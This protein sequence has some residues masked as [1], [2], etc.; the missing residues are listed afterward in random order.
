MER[1]GGREEGPERISPGHP[2]AVRAVKPGRLYR[3]LRERRCESPEL[4]ASELF[5][6][7]KRCVTGALSDVLGRICGGDGLRSPR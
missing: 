6:H 4:I 2:Q 7:E 5:G 3:Y 1:G